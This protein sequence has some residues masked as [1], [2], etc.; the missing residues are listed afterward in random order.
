MVSLIEFLMFD[1]DADGYVGVE[2]AVELFYRRYGRTVLFKKEGVKGMGSETISG[3]APGAQGNKL[4]FHDF[5]KHDLAFYSISRQ[6]KDRAT[7]VIAKKRG[8]EAAKKAEDAPHRPGDTNA[9]GPPPG[10]PRA[11]AGVSPRQR[12]NS[13]VGGQLHNRLF[14][15]GPSSLGA[16]DEAAGGGDVDS[17]GSPGPSPRAR[18][19][20]TR[21]LEAE[22]D[23]SNSPKHSNNSLAKFAAMQDRLGGAARGHL[24]TRNSSRA[25]E[26]GIADADD[27]GA[28]ERVPERITAKEA[29]QKLQTL[30]VRRGSEVIY[31]YHGLSN[32]AADE[33]Q[34]DG[35][36]SGRR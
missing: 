29:L 33:N 3:T 17:A 8:Q 7:Y 4:C 13:I 36:S 27:D 35:K 23:R 22:L 31:T 14:D 20:K 1:L 15:S 30:K 16:V 18:K 10:V 21:A 9:T 25:T 11:G 5:V 19:G 24:V 34:N 6:M 2:E 12:A 28:T 26:S 32:T